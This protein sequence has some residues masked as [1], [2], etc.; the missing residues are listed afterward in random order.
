VAVVIAET[1][2]E[3]AEVPNVT[4]HSSV[5]VILYVD[6]ITLRHPSG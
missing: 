1:V 6:D 3:T 4:Q 2:I 5:R